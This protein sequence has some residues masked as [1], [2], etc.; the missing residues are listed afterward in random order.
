MLKTGD[1]IGIT[2][3]VAD[4]IRHGR[5]WIH[6]SFAQQRLVVVRSVRSENYEN[7]D[8]TRKNTKL[9]TNVV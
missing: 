9:G 8:K 3:Q 4:W 1:G 5:V 2:H 6:R 7:R